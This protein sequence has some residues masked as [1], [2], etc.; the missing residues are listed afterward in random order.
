MVLPAKP[1]VV[2]SSTPDAREEVQ[3][4]V[5]VSPTVIMREEDAYIHERIAS[6]PKSLE[7]LGRIKVHTDFEKTRTQLPDY[8]EA[9]SYDCTVSNP[10]CRAHAWKQDETT[11]RW[12]YGNRGKYIFRWVKNSKR[13][14]DISMNVYGWVFVNRRLFTEAPT[15]LFSANGGVELG[16][17]ILFVLPAEQGLALRH[18]PGKRSTEILKSRITKTKSG[19]ALMTG[20]PTNERYYV[21]EGTGEEDVDPTPSTGIVEGRDF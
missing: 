10:K 7:E 18:A 16:D 17:L 6:Q 4:Y 8:F 1:A 12:S 3:A 15:H 9:F 14:I 13:A 21:P 19:E 5:P 2:P 11:N 20:D